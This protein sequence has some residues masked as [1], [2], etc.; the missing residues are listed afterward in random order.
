MSVVYKKKSRIEEL[1]PGLSGLM[2]AKNEGRFIG[3]SIDSVI[4][5]LDELV[6]V[7]NECT[8]DTENVLLSKVEQYGEKIK[9]CPYKYELLY[10]GL[11]PEQFEYAMSLPED[12]PIFFSSQS[13][14]AIDHV[15]YQYAV[16]IDP[17]QIYFK[18]EVKWWRDVCCNKDISVNISQKM[19]GRFFRLWISFFRRMSAKSG[20]VCSFLMPDWLVKFCQNPYISYAGYLLQKGEGAIAW[21]GINV[22][23]EDEKI[24][25]PYDYRNIHPPYNGEG[26]HILFKV[27]SDTRFRRFIVPS[28]RTKILESLNNPYPLYFAGAMWFHLHAN[29]YYCADKVSEMKR[30]N[31]DLFIDADK[32]ID[33][34]YKDSMSLMHNGVP[35][36]FQKTLFLLVHKISMPAVR[37]NLGKLNSLLTKFSHK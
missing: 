27:S 19:I 10:T 17:D 33:F 9:L 11:T 4:D 23:V 1:K 36:L 29:R 2:R 16:V 3:A 31:P 24:F 25:I 15:S 14:Y 26:D 34:S 30:E 28:N 5:A 13:N 6:V 22:F 8:D 37:K 20:K 35:N 12:S 18:D 21:S 7:Y 32:F